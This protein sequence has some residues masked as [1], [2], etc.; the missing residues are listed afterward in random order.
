MSREKRGGTEVKQSH[1]QICKTK[2]ESIESHERENLEMR[3][4]KPKSCVSRTVPT[5]ESREI[6]TK[7]QPMGLLAI[8]SSSKISTKIANMRKLF[9]NKEMKSESSTSGIVCVGPIGAQKK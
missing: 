9:K 7:N 1:T 4:A 3:S 5:P 2:Q 8:K 6:I